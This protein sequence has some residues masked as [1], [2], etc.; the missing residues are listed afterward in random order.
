MWLIC[1]LIALIVISLAI[2]LYEIRLYVLL[3]GD[4]RGRWPATFGPVHCFKTC[5]HFNGPDPIPKTYGQPVSNILAHV[6][7]SMCVYP[8]I[9][10]MESLR[11]RYK[12]LVEI[13]VIC[14]LIRIRF[15]V[16]PRYCQRWVKFENII[17]TNSFPLI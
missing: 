15:P 11:W 6:H 3:Y 1:R 8:R 17:F 14:V 16:S 2:L 10:P 5:T 7:N 12:N 4:E 9:C 13:S